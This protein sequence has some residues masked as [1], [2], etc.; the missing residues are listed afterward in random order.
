MDLW[1]LALI[2]P[3]FLRRDNWPALG[4]LH[5]QTG[6]RLDASTAAVEEIIVP[7]DIPR[8]GSWLRLGRRHLQTSLQLDARMAGVERFLTNL[9]ILRMP[10]RLC[11][12]KPVEE[13]ILV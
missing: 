7:A 6:I 1:M 2:R 13:R 12:R 3:V 5:L 4:I 8:Q 11:E 9:G 10:Y